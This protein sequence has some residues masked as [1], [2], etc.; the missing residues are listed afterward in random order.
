[1]LPRK[2]PLIFGYGN[3]ASINN[4][5]LSEKKKITGKI[6]KYFELENIIYQNFE[7]QP[8]QDL[9]GNSEI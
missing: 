6:R 1:M 4:P 3:N 2:S 7:T 5:W 9:E 8:M